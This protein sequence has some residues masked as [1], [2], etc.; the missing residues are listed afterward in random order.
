[1]TNN[2]YVIDVLA[3]TGA[4]TPITDTDG[5]DWLVFSVNYLPQTQFS[6]AISLRATVTGGVS[7]QAG[8]QYYTPVNI[9]HSV[10]IN[11]VVENARGSNAV[12]FI[13]GNELAN[14]L[15]ADITR[16]GLGGYDTI[17]GDDGNDLIYGGDGKD[18]LTGDNGDDTLYG[19]GGVDNITGGLGRDLIQGGAGADT[20][21]GGAD[22]GD[23]ISY[24]ESAAAVTIKL[25][26]GTTTT[27][28]GGDAQ[29]DQ[30]NGFTD[31]IGSALNDVIT[32]TN[33]GTL[34][35]GYNDN[36][37]YGGAGNDSLFLGG[38]ADHGY[39]G[40]GIDRLL[41]EAGN[42]TLSG[43][44]GND[45]LYGGLGSD[46]LIGGTGADL[47]VFAAVT[48]STVLSA[49]RDRIS[50]FH[51]AE[52][53]RLYLRDIDAN[54]SLAL[55]QAFTFIGAASFDGRHGLLRI[56]VSGAHSVVYG[57]LNGDKTADFAITVLNTTGL[58]AA[59]FVL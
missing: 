28:A 54:P 38:G 9:G 25:T 30:I 50:D 35:F 42:D 1:M 27:G 20:L 52:G 10:L 45:R 24:S 49:G 11:G 57:D 29:G 59:D 6:T 4:V 22:A 16:T 2:T 46:S 39:G 33:K 40:A 7:V 14:I 18:E 41:G 12:D 56:A 13:V 58:T 8:G 37:F 51:H 23:T 36:R 48:D 53:D 21:G 47:F 43:D 3:T 32:D 17:W 44:A 55:D 31:A 5:I 26:F 19:D 15:Y 34:A